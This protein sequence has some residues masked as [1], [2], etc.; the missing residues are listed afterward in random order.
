MEASRPDDALALRTYF[1]QTERMLKEVQELLDLATDPT[2]DLARDLAGARRRLASAEGRMA[3]LEGNL[4]RERAAAD[5]ARTRA[6]RELADERAARLAAEQEC[7]QCR[8]D[9]D[10]LRQEL[11]LAARNGRKRGR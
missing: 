1:N 3:A 7:H 5:E 2:I 9:R 8:R 6:A 11:R 10:R 4:A